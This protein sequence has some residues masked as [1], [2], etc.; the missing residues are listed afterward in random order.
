[1]PLL[2]KISLQRATGLISFFGVL[3]LIYYL[4][5]K[6]K[7]GNIFI[8]FL[9]IYSLLIL[10]FAKPGIAV[11]HLFLLLYTDI[12]YGRLGP[13]KLH[14]EKIKAIKIFYYTVAIFL[15][16]L[17][18]VSI[19]K[20]ISI[21]EQL[22]TPLQY[23]Y[24]Y[25]GFDF[26]LHGGRFKVDNLFI[27]LVIL[28]VLIAGTIIVIK[29]VKKTCITTLGLIILFVISVS[30][31]WYLERVKYLKWHDRY[32]ETASS[33]LDVQMWAKG[34]T[35]YD[36]LFMPDP[37]HGYGWRDFVDSSSFGSLM[38]WGFASIP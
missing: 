36:A 2:I 12:K 16:F 8:A 31:V 18:L 11:L 34:N 20:L 7:T 37:A 15:F 21:S 33:Y 9:A 27:Y 17:M 19:I 4:F 26:L 25:K 1:M 6:V 24:H 22:W 13:I 29:R 28:S 35:P 30:A 32:A 3:H 10:V 23:F 38:E 5:M 14:H